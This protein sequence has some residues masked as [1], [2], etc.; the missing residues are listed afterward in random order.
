MAVYT[1]KP[2]GQW[3]AR[4]LEFFLR[5]LWL[6]QDF[7]FYP[8]NW[9][10]K[11]FKQAWDLLEVY[12]GELMARTLEYVVANWSDI[13]SGYGLNGGPTLSVVYWLREDLVYEAVN[14]KLGA[15]PPQL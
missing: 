2:K 1:Q 13:A 12:G 11:D 5:D 7:R 15:T 4:D 14:G 10:G 9:T 3:S 8:K 6:K